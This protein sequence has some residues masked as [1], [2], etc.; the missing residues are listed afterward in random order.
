MK[1]KDSHSSVR[2]MNV[3]APFIRDMMETPRSDCVIKCMIP[4]VAGLFHSIDAAH[5]LPN[6]VFFSRLFK[7]RWL[8]HVSDF[9]IGQD[10]IE[11]SSF[12]IELMEV[13][14]QGHHKVEHQMERFQAGSGGGHFVIVNTIML[15]IPLGHIP[16]FVAGDGAQVIA[17]ALAYEF[18]MHQATARGQIGSRH[19]NEDLEVTKAT[20]LFASTGNPEFM[21]W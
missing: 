20:Y 21:L 2:D 16:D 1:S 11:E 15:S 4:D 13:P 7:P 18:A 17:F 14:S 12:D 9:V 6:P 5:E 3:D 19:K 10:T 8:L